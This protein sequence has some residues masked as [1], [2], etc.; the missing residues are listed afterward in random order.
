VEV[1]AG[2]VELILYQ[3]RRCFMLDTNAAKC[4]VNF[5]QYAREKRDYCYVRRFFSSVFLS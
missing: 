3:V 2:A 1:L 5:G 4:A